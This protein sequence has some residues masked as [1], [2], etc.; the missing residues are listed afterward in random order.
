MPHKIYFGD[1]EVLH[2]KTK[3]KMMFSRQVFT[4]LDSPTDEKFRRCV[5]RKIKPAERDDYRIVRI[6]FDTAT[7]T[8]ET[9]Y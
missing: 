5:L 2:L 3:Q 6:C 9:A 7:V 8:G 4:K 1:V